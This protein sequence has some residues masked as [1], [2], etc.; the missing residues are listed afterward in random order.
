MMAPDPGR[1]V[2]RNALLRRRFFWMV[3]FIPSVDKVL[4]DELLKLGGIAEFARTDP[5]LAGFSVTDRVVSERDP[6]PVAAASHLMDHSQKQPLVHFS[7][8]GREIDDLYEFLKR[9]RENRLENILFITGDKL[10]Q[11]SN[12]AARPRYL[13][14]VAAIYA[15]KQL[16]S[17]LLI[18]AAVNPFKYREE[19]AMAQYLKLAKKI[20]AGADYAITQIG[21]DFRKYQE[22][23]SWIK[24]RH[25]A[26]P[27]V[28]NVMPLSAA[29]AR[30]IRKHRLAG[31]TVTDSFME[32]LEAEENRMPDKAKAR[33][34]DR[35][36]LQILGVQLLGYAGVQITGLHS[37]E[38]VSS[39]KAKVEEL[40]QRC[41]DWDAW[42]RSWQAA[43]TL[44][45]GAPARP[46]LE[47]RA[48]FFI[49]RQSTQRTGGLQLKYHV[50]AAIHRWLFDDGWGAAI[51]RL[52][53]R[54]VRRHAALD[55]VLERL[56]RA[57]KSPLFGCETCGMCRLAVTQ[58]VC[59]ETCPK[60]LSN[61]AC[62]GTTENLC[63]FGDRECI[64]S[65]KYRI[66]RDIGRLEQLEKG[67]IPAV[68]K[69]WRG[70]SSWPPYLRHEAPKVHA[71]GT[72]TPE[73][74]LNNKAELQK[75]T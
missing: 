31:V 57:I 26:L 47:G 23:L 9:I 67:I 64:H 68:P 37:V 69:D 33:V 54:P 22:A 55:H 27:L 46:G 6:E 11:V 19:D 34:T 28:A 75:F 50:M 66:A 53:L 7:G 48:S 13:E 29:R 43:L 44:P 24:N 40:R 8:K 39:L 16:F 70:T 21:F 36:A 42:N 35:L 18:A 59:P 65:V 49:G 15:T 25:Q 5:L 20:E 12:G 72:C 38:T 58:Y 17:D 52:L 62:G 63:E 61:G 41:L 14:S 45:S 30:H 60:G 32:L 51:L 71:R 1:N 10:K 2:L 74:G 73:I 3:E 4:R 56:E